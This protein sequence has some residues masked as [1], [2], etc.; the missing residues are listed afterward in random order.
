VINGDVDT[1]R[2]N[3]TVKGMA[4]DENNTFNPN[5]AY[6]DCRILVAGCGGPIAVQNHE[7]EFYNWGFDY[8]SGNVIKFKGKEEDKIGILRAKNTQAKPRLAVALDY[9][10]IFLQE[11]KGKDKKIGKGKGLFSSMDSEKDLKPLVIKINKLSNLADSDFIDTM[12]MVFYSKNGETIT[13][14]G[15]F[16]KDEITKAWIYKPSNSYFD[17]I[18]SKLA[19]GNL[20]GFIKIKLKKSTLTVLKHY[21]TSK[22]WL[23]PIQFI[24]KKL[25][26]LDGLAKLVELMTDQGMDD[27]IVA[28][29]EARE[30]SRIK[31]KVRGYSVQRHNKY[32]EVP[33]FR[34]Y[35]DLNSD[36]YT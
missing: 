29:Y 32:G 5:G 25:L 27:Y 26:A 21:E 23:Y 33:D 18:F 36:E 10:D 16:E 2:S 9:A 17:I 7:N 13:I 4:V 8:P 3:M 12:T 31:T 14:K 30:K 22:E 6:G 28:D 24:S 11:A 15:T 35:R 20:M 34:F 1:F 19:E